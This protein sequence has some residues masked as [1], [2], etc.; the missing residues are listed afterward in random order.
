MKQLGVLLLPPGWDASPSQDTQ[1]E[2]TWSITTPRW[3]GCCSIPGYQV[4]SNL[5]Y[6]YSPL[7]GMLV[8][9]WIGCYIQCSPLHG[10]FSCVSY[11]FT[12][13]GEERQWPLFLS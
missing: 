4:R 6:Y 1:Y 9:H 10:Y 11:K 2:A 7:D 13:L 12:N 3:M 5:E 8:H